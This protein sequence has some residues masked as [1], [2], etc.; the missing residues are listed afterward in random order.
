MN[1]KNQMI[2][3]QKIKFSICQEKQ[4]QFVI[5]FI[6]QLINNIIKLDLVALVKP[7]KSQFILKTIENKKNMLLGTLKR[8]PEEDDE[9]LKQQNNL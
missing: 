6:K 5:L 3:I 8:K 1:F 2:K 7:A 9:N 4:N